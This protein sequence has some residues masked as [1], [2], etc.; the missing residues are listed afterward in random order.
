MATPREK[1][2]DALEALKKL[3]DSGII[4]IR[5][6]HLSRSHRESLMKNGFLQDV[7]KGW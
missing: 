5:S 4:A 6:Q 7:M 3:Q 2:A 1:L